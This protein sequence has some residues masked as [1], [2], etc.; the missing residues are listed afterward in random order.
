MIEMIL[1]YLVVLVALIAFS[2]P[3]WVKYLPKADEQDSYDDRLQ[4]T[5]DFIRR[6]ESLDVLEQLNLIVSCRRLL[7]HIDLMEGSPRLG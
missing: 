7:I 3:L 4:Q 2:T 6:E 5:V 1:S